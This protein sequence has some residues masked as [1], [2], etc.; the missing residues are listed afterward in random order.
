MFLVTGLNYKFMFKET[1][2]L[3]HEEGAEIV[4]AGLSVVNDTVFH[5]IHSKVGNNFVIC[6]KI[7]AF[8]FEFVMHLNME[9]YCQI[10]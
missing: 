1:I 2:R 7:V 5:T 4:N 9:Q 8:V 6:F 3:L 10:F